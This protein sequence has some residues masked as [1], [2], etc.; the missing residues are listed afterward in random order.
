M[1]VKRGAPKKPEIIRLSLFGGAK[2]A[3]KRE[4]RAVIQKDVGPKAKGKM[5]YF[6]AKHGKYAYARGE[7]PVPPGGQ[8]IPPKYG[9]PEYAQPQT[10]V[11]ASTPP[12]SGSNMGVWITGVIIFFV[13]IYVL[14]TMSDGG[15]GGYCQTTCDGY[16]ISVSPGCDCPAGSRYYNTITNGDCIG[17]KQCI[18][19]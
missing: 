4:K 14:V 18:C 19:G 11:Q 10:P 1:A 17:C 3:S 15:G 8:S 12:S 13:I 5:P 9:T 2:E 6:G 16:S 7:T